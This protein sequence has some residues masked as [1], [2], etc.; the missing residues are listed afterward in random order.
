MACKADQQADRGGH[1]VQRLSRIVST[2]Q[3]QLTEHLLT[4]IFVS[5]PHEYQRQFTKWELKRNLTA[6][7]S[8]RAFKVMKERAGNGKTSVILHGG[9]KLNSQKVERLW[10]QAKKAEGLSGN[11]SSFNDTKGVPNVSP[12]RQIPFH[13]GWKFI[14]RRNRL[15]HP[16]RCLPHT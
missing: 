1:E 14:R 3:F 12:I 5:R 10:R 16:Y 8:A 4:V 6:E 2:D 13:L 15:V 9:M 11:A 7:Q